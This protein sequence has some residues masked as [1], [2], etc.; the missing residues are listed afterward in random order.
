[1]KFH[2][3]S[4]K[5]GRGEVKSGAEGRVHVFEKAEAVERASGDTEEAERVGML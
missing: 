1:M 3:S 5:T 2:G 4:G